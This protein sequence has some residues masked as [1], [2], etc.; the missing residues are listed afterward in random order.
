MKHTAVVEFLDGSSVTYICDTLAAAEDCA[1]SMCLNYPDSPV[2]VNGY[3]VQ[4]GPH[5]L[6]DAFKLL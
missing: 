4:T 3:I 1:C 2:C 5:A 6:S